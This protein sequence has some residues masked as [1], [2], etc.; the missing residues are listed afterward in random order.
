MGLNINKW[1]LSCDEELIELFT[2]FWIAYL[3]QKPVCKMS[4]NDQV[5]C[6]L[7]LHLLERAPT[8]RHDLRVNKGL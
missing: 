4:T 5:L 2:M 8:L 7:Q 6:I 1:H 3:K